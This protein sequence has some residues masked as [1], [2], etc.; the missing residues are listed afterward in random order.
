M[1]AA[2][3][4]VIPVLPTLAEGFPIDGQLPHV[5]GEPVRV[6][7]IHE[8]CNRVC[9]AVAVTGDDVGIAALELPVRSYWFGVCPVV[10]KELGIDSE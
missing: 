8:E 6:E 3:R 7:V 5:V 9:D 2:R 10:L 1:S 4:D